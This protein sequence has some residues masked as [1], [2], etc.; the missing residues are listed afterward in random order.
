MRSFAVVFA[1]S[2]KWRLMAAFV[3]LIGFVVGV[4]VAARACNARQPMR[5]QVYARATRLNGYRATKQ[6]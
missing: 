3:T 5:A 1:R 2:A 6:R 4:G